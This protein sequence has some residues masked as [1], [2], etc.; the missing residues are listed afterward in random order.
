MQI[1]NISQHWIQKNSKCELWN[2]IS[3]WHVFLQLKVLRQVIKFQRFTVYFI[4]K[5]LS[6]Q[7]FLFLLSPLTLRSIEKIDDNIMPLLYAVLEKISYT[8]MLYNICLHCSL[9][10]SLLYPIS[11]LFLNTFTPNNTYY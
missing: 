1:C 7:E 5:I 8:K 10:P 9:S 2:T 11:V 6:F 4:P 3:S